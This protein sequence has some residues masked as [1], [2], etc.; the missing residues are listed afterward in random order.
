MNTK[1]IK[2]II[3]SA[4]V[5]IIVAL[6]SPVFILATPAPQQVCTE[7][8]QWHDLT[9]VELY[10]N[11][12]R[13]DVM[14]GRSSPTGR[15]LVLPTD[16]DQPGIF[17]IEV[18]GDG[19]SLKFD[20]L[21]G[22]GSDLYNVVLTFPV[23]PGTYNWELVNTSAVHG[24]VPNVFADEFEQYIDMYSGNVP[25]KYLGQDNIVKTVTGSGV[26]VEISYMPAGSSISFQLQT[27]ATDLPEEITDPYE[28]YAESFL[29]ADK[30]VPCPL[31]NITANKVWVDG[32][33]EHPTIYLQLFRQIG[34]GAPEA[35]PGQVI[36]ELTNGTTSVSW[37][38]INTTDEYLKDYTFFVKEV[39]VNGNPVTPEGYTKDENGLTVTN[40]FIIEKTTLLAQ[41]AWVN[42]PEEHPTVYLKIFR[43]I[44]VGTPEAVPGAA[45]K[46]LADGVLQVSWE[47]I[48]KTN[49]QG[50]EYIFSVK[51]VNASGD[52]FTPKHYFKEESGLL[53]TNTYIVET[54]SVSA[55]KIW[56]DQLDTH[57]KIY[58]KLYRQL[59]DNEPEAIPE[60]AI[61]ELANGVTSVTWDD[62]E[63][64]DK[65]GDPYVF[66]VKEVNADGEDYTP[67]FYVK[68]ETGLTVT[69]TYRDP[70]GG[71]TGDTGGEGGSGGTN[72]PGTIVN[73]TG[74]GLATKNL[75]QTGNSLQIVKGVAVIATGVVVLGATRI[76]KRYNRNK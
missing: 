44:G 2:T 15:L 50:V 14:F 70:S 20:Q 49:A 3:L 1:T 27:R 67:P 36:K 47:G 29:T 25:Q 16:G 24:A 8:I 42:G 65:N 64:T 76:R 60:A 68:D 12:G 63:K 39:D 28:L 31:D 10:Q 73:V 72:N 54:F 13:D 55:T 45:I 74:G 51:E 22:T 59:G 58:F 71:G 11:P 66:F 38:A 75:P 32:P 7:P 61:M 40:T 46:E 33:V 57:P 21:L 18:S 37:T 69:N 35:V 43:Q 52:D 4:F 56:D 48:D 34:T 53:V 26:I 62:I 9:N 17:L 41:K 6:L 5:F 19:D 30:V 23:V